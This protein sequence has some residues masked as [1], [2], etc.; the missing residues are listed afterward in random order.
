M[1]P[2]RP[3]RRPRSC[4]R[5]RPGVA[6]WRWQSIAWNDVTRDASAPDQSGTPTVH[7]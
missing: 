3:S 1:Y 6:D 2:A 5:P 4:G 7:L